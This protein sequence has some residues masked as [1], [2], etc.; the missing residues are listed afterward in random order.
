MADV[1]VRPYRPSRPRVTVAG[2]VSIERSSGASY[3]HTQASPL[4]TWTVNHN[5]NTD[6]PSVSVCS[7]GGIELDAQVVHIS[8]NQALVSFNV[9][10]AGTARVTP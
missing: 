6:R 9:P 1:T 8:P 4:S 10:T 7:V 2:G 5:L 3:L